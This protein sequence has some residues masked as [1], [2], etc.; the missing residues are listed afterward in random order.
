MDHKKKKVW[1]EEILNPALEK[2]P[3]RAENF[4]T[5]SGI[6]LPRAALP[7]GRDSDELLSFPGEYPFTRGVYPTMY[8]GRLWTMRQYAGYASAEE[9]N[10]RFRYLLDQGQTGLSVAFDLPTQLGYDPD[11]PLA[12]GEV[13]RLGV[14]ISSLADMEALLDGIPLDRVSTSMTINAPAAVLLAMYIAVARRQGVSLDELRGTVQN[15]ILKEYIARGTYIFPPRQSLRLTT[16]LIQYCQREVPHWN[17][18]SISGY[19]IREA[20]ATAVQEVA[21]TL[22]NG[23][24]YVDA[25]REVGLDLNDFGRR[26]SFFFSADNDFLEEVAKFRAA[27][28]LWAELMKERCGASDPEACKLRFHTQTAGSTLTAQQPYNN[29]VRVA[30]QALSA[31]LGGTQSLHTNSMD[32]ALQLPSEQAVQ[33]AL[34]TQQILAEESGVANTVD[35]L[36]GSYLIEKLTREISARVREYLGKIEKRGGSLA[37]IESG[38]IQAE[39]QDSAYKQQLARESGK[40]VQVGVNAYQDLEEEI[41]IQ[42]PPLDPALE[43]DRLLALEKVRDQRDSSQVESLLQD[44]R[45]A[46]GAEENLLPILVDCVE[47]YTTLGEICGALRE[48]WGEYR[49]R[50]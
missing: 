9:T 29:I 47:A 44:L 11:Y 28:L 14:S 33:I 39:I 17:T 5:A 13:G 43:E 10:R 8:R 46:A 21:F 50:I 15:D 49:E 48:V 24:A 6:P 4:Q 36:G 19:H 42:V 35:P 20:G 40:S 37:A 7:E 23:L 26:L 27:R 25:A 38:F 3:E 2:Q 1:E 22:A 18:I 45:T 16:D 34:R 30:L 12:E 31:V 41:K 32:E